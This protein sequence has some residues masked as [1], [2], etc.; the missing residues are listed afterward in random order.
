MMVMVMVTMMMDNRKLQHLQVHI[1]RSHLHTGA[2]FLRDEPIQLGADLVAHCAE[3][4]D[5]FVRATGVARFDGIR[6]VS[7]RS[8]AQHLFFGEAAAKNIRKKKGGGFRSR[9]RWA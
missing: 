3:I 1:H 5:G 7:R 9:V 6:M 4:N 2:A 8:Y